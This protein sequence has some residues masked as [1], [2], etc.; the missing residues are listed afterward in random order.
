MS[1]WYLNQMLK[2]APFGRKAPYN[3]TY[4]GRKSSYIQRHRSTFRVK[5]G[6][7]GVLMQKFL[8]T[9]LMFHGWRTEQGSPIS[10]RCPCPNFWNLGFTRGIKMV[11]GIDVA[12]G[13]KTANQLILK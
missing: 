13:M 9:V 1:Q 3:G 4:Y 10:Q 2:R 8:E 12:D 6:E 7:T 5:H 11:D